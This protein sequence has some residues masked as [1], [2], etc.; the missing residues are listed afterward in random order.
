[1][2]NSESVL[3]TSPSITGSTSEESVAPAVSQPVIQQLQVWQQRALAAEQKVQQ[4]ND[5]IRGG[6]ISYMREWLKQKLFRDLIADRAQL[7]ESQHLATLKALAVD[8]RLGR[9]EIQIQ[10]QNQVYEQRIERLTQELAVTKE[11]SRALI[12][13]QITQ[14]KSEMEAARV[15]LVAEDARNEV[16]S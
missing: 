11:E 10:Q 12:R 16:A 9:L 15:R 8:E 3:I 7:L 13:V 5:V 4:A 14:I 6:L 2:A 1:M